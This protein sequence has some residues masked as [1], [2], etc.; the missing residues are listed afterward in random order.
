MDANTLKSDIDLAASVLSTVVGLMP[1][2]P[3]V[4]A[5]VATMQSVAENPVILAMLVALINGI[6]QPM[7]A[8]RADAAK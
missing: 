5:Y 2:A 3:R 8:Q 4:Q 1:N 7:T 6:A